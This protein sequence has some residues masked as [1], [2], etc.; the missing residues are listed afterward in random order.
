M[1]ITKYT[2]LKEINPE[3]REIIGVASTEDEDR[4]GEVI[5]QSGLNTKIF[6]ETNPILLAN[7][8]GV[9]IRS[10]LGKITEIWLKGNKTMFK[11]KFS[12]VNEL[13]VQAYEMVKEGILNTFSIGFMAKEYDKNTITK[14]ELL[15]ISLVPIP[16][17]PN[18]IVM[19]KGY[20]GEFADKLNKYWEKQGFRKEEDPKEEET[21]EETEDKFYNYLIN[22]ND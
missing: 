7:H 3:N 18:A 22:K 16:A 21:E 6:I 10:V 4:D 17:N 11:A 9:D 15:E 12:K 13:A 20:K 14:S 5:K 8:D 1:L 2:Q 19:A